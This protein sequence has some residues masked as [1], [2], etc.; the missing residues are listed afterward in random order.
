MLTTNPHQYLRWVL[1]NFQVNHGKGG[2]ALGNAMMAFQS[3]KNTGSH[4]YFLQWTNIVW[5]LLLPPPSHPHITG[6]SWQISNVSLHWILSQS[7]LRE[8]RLRDSCSFTGEYLQLFC[9]I[10]VLLFLFCSYADPLNIEP[11]HQERANKVNHLQLWVLPQGKKQKLSLLWLRHLATMHFFFQSWGRPTLRS[12]S[13]CGQKLFIMA[14]FLMEKKH[15]S[16]SI[17]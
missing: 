10:S 2:V 1:F 5:I 9:W 16:S 15:I 17:L 11:C 4:H 3:R 14:L 12:L 7:C 8:A 6:L 13:C